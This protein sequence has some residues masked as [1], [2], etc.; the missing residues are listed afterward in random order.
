MLPS[1]LTPIVFSYVIDFS[2][3]ARVDELR[4]C[5]EK[6]KWLDGLK[7]LLH[8]CPW[9]VLDKYF[10]DSCF[11]GDIETCKW[12]WTYIGPRH[13]NLDYALRKSCQMNQ[14]HVAQWLTEN[15]SL[16]RK[17]AR[18]GDNF[19]LRRSCSNGHL[20]VAQ[21]LTLTFGLTQEDA[22]TLNNFALRKACAKRS[23][24]CGSV[25]SKY[26]QLNAK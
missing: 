4:H 20:R 18:A 16:T 11:Y 17:D 19:A 22:R 1:D 15:F 8:G 9:L 24:R 5:T 25:A 26:I 6:G 10:S 21:W 2:Q 12:F 23:F 3:K 7:C 13:M 14:L